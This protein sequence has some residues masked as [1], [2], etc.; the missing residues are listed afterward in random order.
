MK[1]FLKIETSVKAGDPR[2]ISPRS[3]EF[4]SVLGPYISAI[5]HC[6]RYHPRLVKGLDNKGREEK[7]KFL[8]NFKHFLEEDYARYDMSVSIDYLEQVE[9]QFL[10]TPFIDDDH[11]LY[12]FAMRLAMVTF[13]VSE[14]GLNYKVEGTRCSGDAH[15][16]IGNGLDNDFNN[17]IAFE[18]LPDD[19]WCTVSEGDD[20]AAGIHKDWID[21]AIYNLHIL[22]CLGFQLKLD[23]YRSIDQ[24]SFCGR[25]LAETV[26]GIVST[27]DLNR[28]LAKL[29]TI[30]SDG[31]PESLTLAKMISYYYSDARTPILGAFVTT[32]IHLLLPRVNHRRLSRA[33]GHL[34]KKLWDRQRLGAVNFFA[35]DYP[36]LDPYPEVRSMIA[37]RTGY[38]F[39]MQYEFESYYKSFGVLGY[40]PNIID[41]IQ[42]EWGVDNNSEIY[43]SI[44]T[45]VC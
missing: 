2:N 9:Y 13:G 14:I 35:T 21:Q 31:D 44:D 8:S 40:I 37:L 45:F 17:F 7:L 43:G 41:K 30:C 22:P 20:G 32:V 39:G 28:S 3:D 15:T 26:S 18:P 12:R 11:Y 33:V 5:E 24:M 36:Y 42:A 1:C 4:L 38:D 27:C 34:T 10:T 6:L 29:H 23:R 19:A 25:Y 16:S